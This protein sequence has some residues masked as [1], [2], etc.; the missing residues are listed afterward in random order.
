[1]ADEQKLEMFGFEYDP[2][3]EWDFENFPDVEEM[4]N[5]E[6]REDIIGEILD[7]G[8]SMELLPDMIADILRDMTEDE[9][10]EVSDDLQ[11]E[12]PFADS[13][14]NGVSKDS[15]GF[16]PRSNDTYSKIN[17]SIADVEVDPKIVEQVKLE[18]TEEI[19]KSGLS[20]EHMD[21]LVSD[22]LKDRFEQLKSIRSDIEHYS[23][24]YE[25]LSESSNPMHLRSMTTF[26][27]LRFEIDSAC[28]D[29]V[30]A[31]GA[32]GEGHFIERDVSAS[33]LGLSLIDVVRT[34]ALESAIIRGATGV[35]IGFDDIYGGITGEKST[36]GKIAF[37]FVKL[38]EIIGEKPGSLLHDMFERMDKGP[39]VDKP[40]KDETPDSQ[41][42]ND[43]K[44]A[45]QSAD[46]EVP[47][48]E[49][50]IPEEMDVPVETEPVTMEESEEILEVST[51]NEPEKEVF[52]PIDEE[53]VPVTVAE[54]ETD[55]AVETDSSEDSDSEESKRD[56]ENA[57]VSDDEESEAYVEE[58]DEASTE[59]E[60]KVK[61]QEQAVGEPQEDRPAET[62]ME[63]LSDIAV[64]QNTDLSESSE[65]AMEQVDSKNEDQDT[66]A[67]QNEPLDRDEELMDIIDSATSAIENGA[68]EQEVL[69]E[70]SDKISDYYESQMADPDVSKD[71]I[72]NSIADAVHEIASVFDDPGS[73]TEALL[74]GI[75]DEV[76][77]EEILSRIE[78]VH[79]DM[80]VEAT[81]SF[82]DVEYDDSGNVIDRME[83]DAPMEKVDYA[84][85]DLNSTV[86]ALEDYME[87]AMEFPEMKD[88]VSND[89]DHMLEIPAG[90]DFS[91]SI[92]L[93]DIGSPASEAVT[94]V[95]IEVVPELIELFL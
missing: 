10:D 48:S 59:E 84:P 35:S 82:G 3:G 49:S 87:S 16:R 2:V 44:K 91:G 11:G 20:G 30:K 71:D 26:Q 14:V 17:K 28:R 33:Q 60:T 15:G 83:A 4:D 90:D 52:Q 92:G 5:L 79:A 55:S 95:G 56:S 51:E 1:M 45:E 25:K 70:V 31:G 13:Q 76:M 12:E 62:D 89:F 73:A 86:D 50:V 19:I 66:V 40:L 41:V 27:L 61:D 24:L 68:D 80:T 37:P 77:K 65:V 69:S 57:A 29:Y 53:K 54:E 63:D 21:V 88:I 9:M 32:V 39:E 74:D 81:G 72:V 23:G 6:S 78:D 46:T 38:G 85:F 22:R 64:D 43:S 7:S 93:E 36:V 42:D 75:P 58:D 34:N 47:V 18:I 8:E 94:D 67:N